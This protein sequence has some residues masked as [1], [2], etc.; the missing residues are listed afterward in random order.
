MVCGGFT[1]PDSLISSPSVVIAA[2]PNFVDATV[3]D[4]FPLCLEDMRRRFDMRV[5]GYVV[6]PEHVHLLLS[7][8]EHGTLAEAIHYLKLSFA[9][10]L[11]SRRQASARLASKRRTR[12]WGTRHQAA[13]EPEVL[14][15]IGEES[16]RKG[17]DVLTSKQIDQVIRAARPSHPVAKSGRQG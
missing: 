15:V 9:K 10:R 11:R 13:P 5:Y 14:R 3:Y 2:S 12:T 8:P 4:L 6:M 16:K 1:N 7:E 17:T